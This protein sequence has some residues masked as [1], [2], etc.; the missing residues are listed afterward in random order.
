MQVQVAASGACE[1]KWRVKPRGEGVEVERVTLAAAEERQLARIDQG[2]G[3]AELY[4][5]GVERANGNE[6]A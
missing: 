6:A 5:L 4:R 2:D 3:V 1:Q